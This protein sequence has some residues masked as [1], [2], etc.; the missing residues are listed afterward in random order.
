[1]TARQITGGCLC[2]AVTVTAQVDAPVLRACHCEMCRQ[3]TSG[4]YVS[5]KTVP[6]TVHFTG[7]AKSY[8]SSDWAERGFCAICGS[9][10]WYGTL[11]DGVRH[12]SAGLFENA[13]GAPLVIE[14]FEDNRPEG[15][16]FA[17]DHKKLTTSQTIELFTGSA[18]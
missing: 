3:H 5:I 4:A 17:G 11:A 15:Y 10:L 2:G 9:T 6:G 12:P 8:R 1:M 14:F 18:S 16:A 13:E 7:P